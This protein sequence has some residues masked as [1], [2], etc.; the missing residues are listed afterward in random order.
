MNKA[1][2]NL[3]TIL[4][5][6]ITG[7]GL[8]LI[9]S[10]T[11][12]VGWPLS[13]LLSTGFISLDPILYI[14]LIWAVMFALVILS[15]IFYTAKHVRSEN[16]WIIWGGLNIFALAVNVLAIADLIPDSLVIYAYWHPWLLS[17]GL[18]YA[19][20]VILGWNDRRITTFGT[21]IFGLGS[22]L[23]IAGLVWSL[24]VSYSIPYLTLIGFVHIFPMMLSVIERRLNV[25]NMLSGNS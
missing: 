13:Y 3:R 25:T 14:V 9:G 21:G 4:K 2:R 8:L 11:G 16:L 7:D 20:T 1:L 15:G 5:P 17:I 24:T 19:F 12:V 23:S 10:V 22:A 6:P 18:G